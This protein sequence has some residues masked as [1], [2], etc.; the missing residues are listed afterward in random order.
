TARPQAVRLASRWGW[1]DQAITTAAQQRLFNDYT[2]LYPQPFDPE[3]RAAA[4]LSK[5]PR[6]LIYSVMRQESLYRTDAVSSAGA[7]GL[8]QM[9]PDTAR[10][11][12]RA[13]QQPKPSDDALFAPNVAIVLGAAQVSTLLACVVSQT[14]SAL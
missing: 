2:L 9:M 13:W 1:H 3:V 6:E 4:Q 7:R 14:V 12:A 5:L 8:L 10:R 11:T